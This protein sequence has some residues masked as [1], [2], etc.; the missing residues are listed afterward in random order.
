MNYTITVNLAKMFAHVEPWDCSNSEANLGPCA[1]RYTWSAAQEVA[2]DWRS[3]LRPATKAGFEDA[4]DAMGSWA[5]STGAWDKSEI[6]TWPD[7]D[8]LALLVQNIASEIRQCEGCDDAETM[9]DVVRIL[10]KSDHE[11]VTSYFYVKGGQP[12]VDYYAGI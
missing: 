6:D 7:L 4:C 12:F 8:F 2:K 9:V 3:W 1:A 10:R 5:R 11:C